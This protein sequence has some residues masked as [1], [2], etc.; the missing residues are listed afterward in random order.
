MLPGPFSSVQPAVKPRS[1]DAESRWGD[2]NSRWRDACP[3]QF[4]YCQG[5]T[6]QGQ[7]QEFPKPRPRTQRA[8]VFK[9][10]VFAQTHR[11]FCENSGALKN[12]KVFIKFPRGLWRAPTRKT[13]MVMTLAH[14]QQIKKIVL[15]SNRG[16]G[17]FEDL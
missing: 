11:K 2:A 17:I 14:F 15:S 4:K 13:N 1:E 6:L 7:G 8:S 12:K 9:K 5:P 3:L 16:Q 10:K